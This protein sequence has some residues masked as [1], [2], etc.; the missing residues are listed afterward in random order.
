MFKVCLL[1]AR[2]LIR[3]KFATIKPDTPVDGM[4]CQYPFILLGGEK[5]CE[6]KLKCLAQEHNAVTPA[7]ARTQ[8]ARSGVQ[9][10]NH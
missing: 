10:A 2:W 1:Q 6:S 5:H 8:T 9:R 7:R 4:I 3:H